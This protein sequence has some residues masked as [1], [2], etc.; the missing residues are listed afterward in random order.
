MIFCENSGDSKSMEN[1][2]DFDF[3]TPHVSFKKRREQALKGLKNSAEQLNPKFEEFDVVVADNT[4][5][6]LT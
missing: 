4:P 3:S 5:L 1:D 6:T 2:L